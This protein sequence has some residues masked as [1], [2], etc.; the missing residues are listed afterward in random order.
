MVIQN[1]T[2]AMNAYRM[3]GI[4]TRQMEQAMERINSG[5]RINSAKDDA[6]GL[7]ISEK[8][9]AQIRG[10]QQASANSQDAQMLVRTAEGQLG[11]IGE[12]LQQMRALS[13]KAADD[14]NEDVDRTAIQEEIDQLALEITRISEDAEHN[15]IKLLDGSFSGKKFQ[16]GANAGQSLE[17]TI[18]SSDA[19][20]LS[21]D[22]L[23]VSD[24]TGASA[25]ITALDTAINTVTA[26][27][28]KL[29]ATDN[30]L[31]HTIKN[32]DLTAENLQAAES[33]IRDA[34]VAKEMMDFMKYNILQQ[35]SMSMMAQANMQPQQ[36]LR[37]LG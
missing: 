23:D 5:Y 35:A 3:M 10:M 22:A 21:V 30:R 8:M 29:G 14:S 34:D 25:A 19:S 2:S 27:R 9:R 16:I 26:E 32:L 37:L 7:G 31:K 15:N 28:S 12:M 36:V 20:D 33:R 1:N 4:N 11:S 13:V 17:V 18:A 24:A 6:S